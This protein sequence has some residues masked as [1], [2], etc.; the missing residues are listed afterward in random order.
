MLVVGL[1]QLFLVLLFTEL[2]EGLLR[3]GLEALESLTQQLA[4]LFPRV[5]GQQQSESGP[6]RPA[7]QQPEHSASA[8]AALD[9]DQAA[10]VLLRHP[11]LLW[12]VLLARLRI[13]HRAAL[14]LVELLPADRKSTRLNSSHSQIS[15][16]VFCLKKKKIIDIFYLI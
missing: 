3:G 5:R 6:D 16:A 7:Q 15:Y 10:I 2:L 14:G 1:E 11:V 8:P 13:V 9:H 12:L 4:R